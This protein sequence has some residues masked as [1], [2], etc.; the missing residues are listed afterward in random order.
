VLP[1]AFLEH[2]PVPI[3]YPAARAACLAL[4][5]PL[6]IARQWK[7]LA[8]IRSPASCVDYATTSQIKDFSG[9]LASTPGF[10]WM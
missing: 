10:L 4:Q 5:M 3:P 9:K 6:E 1:C 8:A 7:G 2:D